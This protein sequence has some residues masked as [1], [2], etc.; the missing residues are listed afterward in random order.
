MI[1]TD[2]NSQHESFNAHPKYFQLIQHTVESDL[3][4]DKIPAHSFHLQ[5]RS[6]ESTK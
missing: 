6:C 5:P 1:Q 4:A 2:D 3:S